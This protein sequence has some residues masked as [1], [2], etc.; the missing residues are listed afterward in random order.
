M[1]TFLSN[2]I[3]RVVQKSLKT[4][5]LV[6]KGVK[7]QPL[8]RFSP[9]LE[10]RVLKFLEE[11]KI[12]LCCSPFENQRRKFTETETTNTTNT[13]SQKNSRTSM[14]ST[15]HGPKE[16]PLKMNVANSSLMMKRGLKTLATLKKATM[17]DRPH[18][19]E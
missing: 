18:P 2:R 10:T 14:L 5:G 3:G 16:V 15:I 13:P 12:D 17:E 4:H 11:K 6:G 19:S 9:S 8:Y 7:P 1:G